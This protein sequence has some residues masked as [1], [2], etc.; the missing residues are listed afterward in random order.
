M[1]YVL[2]FSNFTLP[3][4]KSELVDGK[5]FTPEELRW[6][7]VRAEFGIGYRRQVSPGNQDNMFAADL[8]VEP[9]FLYFHKSSDAAANFIAPH[10]TPELRFHLQTRYDALVRKTRIS[11]K[12]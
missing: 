6:G 5:S 7:Y 12:T 3:F 10:N 11:L 1:E 9:G 4:A 8:L 2:S